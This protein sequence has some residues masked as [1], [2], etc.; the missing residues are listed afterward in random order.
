MDKKI[1]IITNLTQSINNILKT[2][3]I[4]TPEVRKEALVK[5]EIESERKAAKIES[6]Q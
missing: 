3:V 5:K 6:Q 1:D 2:I 4:Q